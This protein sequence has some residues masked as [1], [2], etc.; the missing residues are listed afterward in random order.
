MSTKLRALDTDVKTE[1]RSTL[2]SLGDLL[3]DISVRGA[4]HLKPDKLEPIDIAR[5]AKIGTD[6][7]VKA[8]GMDE[9]KIRIGAIRSPDDLEKLDER[10]LWRLAAMLPPEDDDDASL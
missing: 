1:V 3:V 5:F 9:L 8:A 7:K 4:A 2:G 6:L 10:D